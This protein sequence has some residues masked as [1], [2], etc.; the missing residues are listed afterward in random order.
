[1]VRYMGF[2]D[3]TLVGMRLYCP[4]ADEIIVNS[5]TFPSGPD[6]MGLQD[7]TAALEHI[8]VINRKK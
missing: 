4:N 1:M 8:G 3:Y 6:L 2:E 7:P 5:A